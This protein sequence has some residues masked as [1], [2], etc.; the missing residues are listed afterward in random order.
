M[1]LEFKERAKSRRFTENVLRERDAGA[2]KTFAST[3]WN[4]L[5]TE[6]LEAVSKPP[7]GRSNLM[8]LSGL[9]RVLKPA[10]LKIGNFRFRSTWSLLS[11]NKFLN[12]WEWPAQAERSGR[13]L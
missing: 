12:D 11:G 4:F 3:H 2:T 13:N 9:K 8:I 6:L 10:L 7:F 5:R 1:E